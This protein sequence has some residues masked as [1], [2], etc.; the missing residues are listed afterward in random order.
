[1]KILNLKPNKFIP[2][3]H[4]VLQHECKGAA[5]NVSCNSH[6]RVTAG[7]LACKQRCEYGMCTKH[8]KYLLICCEISCVL[9]IFIGK[10]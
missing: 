5:C 3:H 9:F 8:I 2:R 4:Q 10:I 6:V 1:M 7:R